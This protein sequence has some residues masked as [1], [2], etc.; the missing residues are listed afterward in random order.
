MSEL[1][2]T[3]A[4]LKNFARLHPDLSVECFECEGD[5]KQFFENRMVDCWSCQGLGIVP[6]SAFMVRFIL[7]GGR[8]E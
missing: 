4:E 8:D 3:R 1:R 6:Y 2:N 7:D 5:G